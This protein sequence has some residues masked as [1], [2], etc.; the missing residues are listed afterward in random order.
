LKLL[1]KN[2][3]CST[4][5]IKS[6]I[7]NLLNTFEVALSWDSRTLLIPSMLPT[8]EMLISGQIK[9]DIRIPIRV[10]GTGAKSFQSLSQ[11]STPL[12][13]SPQHQH[14]LYHHTSTDSAAEPRRSSEIA[15]SVENP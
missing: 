8:E 15:C 11:C 2:I 6:Y 10:R 1:F 9:A 14:R 12:P 7:I 5:D 4:S 13:G 3:S